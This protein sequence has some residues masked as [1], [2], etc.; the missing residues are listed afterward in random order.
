MG[1]D[2]N[3]V[4]ITECNFTK[5]ETFPANFSNK[6]SKSDYQWNIR[7]CKASQKS[8]SKTLYTNSLKFHPL[9]RLVPVYRCNL[10]FVP[11][12]CNVYCL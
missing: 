9:C 6:F 3:V 1:C 12:N 5:K 8:F 4:K 10:A 2:F 7:I 11:D